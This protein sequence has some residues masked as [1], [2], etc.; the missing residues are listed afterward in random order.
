MLS[1]LN[2]AGGRMSYVRIRDAGDGLAVDFSDVPSPATDDNGHVNF[3]IRTIAAGLDRSK[4]HTIRFSIDFVP[5]EDNDVVKVYVDGDL[6]V[7]GSRGRTTT[8]TTSSPLRRT[9]CRSSTS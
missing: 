1:L 4:P 8:V 7:T 9:R 5:G 6:K 2:G 3:D